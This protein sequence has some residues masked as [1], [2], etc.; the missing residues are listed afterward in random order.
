MA[1][2]ANYRAKDP[3]E[4]ITLRGNH[5]LKEIGPSEKSV[6]RIEQGVRVTEEVGRDYCRGLQ[7]K[8]GT[9]KTF[10]DLF[11][12]DPKQP[13]DPPDYPWDE[14]LI[15][16]ERV[17]QR[18]FA[19]PRPEAL[20]TFPGFSALFT[21]LVCAKAKPVRAG[22]HT[23][24]YTALLV[25]KLAQEPDWC[26]AILTRPTN[27]LKQFKILLPKAVFSYKR[28]IVIDDTLIS[29][30]TMRALRDEF[31]KPAYEGILVEFACCVWHERLTHS[32]EVPPEICGIEEPVRQRNFRMPWGDA[33]SFEDLDL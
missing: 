16:A 6:Q 29:G 5:G 24:I 14:V 26:Q 3:Q 32:D 31:R 30:V 9:P 15:G 11:V 20:V 2:V 13:D 17:A 1:R 25:N 18:V 22:F 27:S 19:E 23:P 8:T 10:E 33:V 4:L 7:Q 21:G 12:F 28:L